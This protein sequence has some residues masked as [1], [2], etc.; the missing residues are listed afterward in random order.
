MYEVR[1]IPAARINV[2]ILS[3]AQTQQKTKY[4]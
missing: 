4:A 3:V 2:S 1:N